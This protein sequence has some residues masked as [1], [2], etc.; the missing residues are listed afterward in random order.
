MG[1]SGIG[2]WQLLIILAIVILIFGTKRLP[3]AAK[4]LGSAITNFREGMKRDNGE[5]T[6]IEENKD[7]DA[8]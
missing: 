8:K 1:F 4:D 7:E 6:K 5:T 2:I 3:G